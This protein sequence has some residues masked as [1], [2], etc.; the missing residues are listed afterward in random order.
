MFKNM[1]FTKMIITIVENR[2][3]TQDSVAKIVLKLPF[4][5]G[6]DPPKYRSNWLRNK[7]VTAFLKKVKTVDVTFF[8]LDTVFV[9]CLVFDKEYHNE[10][11]GQ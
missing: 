10:R 9:S 5:I 8:L 6:Y 1:R 4:I 11:V 2:I 7:K 3:I